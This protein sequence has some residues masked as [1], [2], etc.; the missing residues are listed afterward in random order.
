MLVFQCIFMFSLTWSVGGSV[1]QNGRKLFD[2][3]VRELIAVSTCLVSPLYVA[4][5]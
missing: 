2:N 5:Q 3:L 4:S 1:D